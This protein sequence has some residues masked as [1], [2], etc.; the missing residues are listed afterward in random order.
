MFAKRVALRNRRKRNRRTE[1]DIRL[2]RRV[3]TAAIQA[4]Q[5]AQIRAAAVNL[6]LLLVRKYE[7]KSNTVHN[8]RGL[9]ARKILFKTRCPTPQHLLILFVSIYH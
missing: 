3:V 6:A 2:A 8:N 7:L 1:N 9:I 4:I 5:V